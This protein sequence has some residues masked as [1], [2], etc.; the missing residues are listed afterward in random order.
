MIENHFNAPPQ[1]QQ[2]R[3]QLEIGSIM[4]D[5]SEK[6]NL[7]SYMLCHQVKYHDTFAVT[8][9]KLPD[10]A[11]TF[12]YVAPDPVA[13]TGNCLLNVEPLTG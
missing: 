4:R 13:L 5:S 11:K 9:L 10:Q 12:G 2:K 1:K 6:Q 3:N 7:L 8:N